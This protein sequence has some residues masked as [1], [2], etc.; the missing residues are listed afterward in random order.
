MTLASFL[1]VIE[2]GP[3]LAPRQSLFLLVWA[4]CFQAFG[5]QPKE[6]KNEGSHR[7]AKESRHL[8]TLNKAI[9]QSK[10]YAVENN[11]GH[12]S[13]FSGTPRYSMEP[14][15]CFFHPREVR[16]LLRGVV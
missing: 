6:L 5:L 14:R 11:H 13:V 3:E 12:S 7:I 8:F 2:N 15:L 10:E 4:R 1:L 16:L 9:V